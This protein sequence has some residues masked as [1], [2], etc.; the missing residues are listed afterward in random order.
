MNGTI[1]SKGV[2]TAKGDGTYEY[3]DLSLT[4]PPQAAAGK[5]TAPLDVSG[6]AAVNLHVP[7]HPDCDENWSVT[8]TLV[9]YQ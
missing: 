4:L 7:G 5:F 8:G 6:T 3:E 2:M 1:S 9:P